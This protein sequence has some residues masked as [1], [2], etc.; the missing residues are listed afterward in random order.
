LKRI[1]VTD[2]IHSKEGK[3]AVNGI[4]AVFTMDSVMSV[5]TA[6]KTAKDK[7]QRENQGQNPKKRGLFEQV[8]NLAINE[9]QAPAQ[10]RTV[11]YGRDGRVSAMQYQTR[12]YNY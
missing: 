11:V 10:F 1:I 9:E 4:Y 2:G 3:K 5:A 7:K 12:D 6:E 8:L